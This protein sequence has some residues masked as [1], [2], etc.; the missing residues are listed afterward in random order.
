[1]SPDFRAVR[2]RLAARY[3]RGSGLEIGALHEPL[4]VPAPASVRYVDRLSAE[5]Q[6][7]H[8]PELAGEALVPVDVVDDGE[9]LAT[10]ADASVDFVIANHF[11]EHCEDPIA[12][13]ATFLRVVRSGGIV[14]LAVPDKRFSF[15]AG[16]EIT[17]IGHLLEDHEGGVAA[18]RRGHYLDWAR[19]VLGRNGR[20]AEQEADRLGEARYSI[21]FHVW[22]RRAFLAFLRWCRDDRKMPFRIVRT[23]A[24]R[25]EVIAVLEKTADGEVR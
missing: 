10:I 20:E 16:R 18:S 21:H 1:V 17:T 11:L 6:R 12:A 23:A 8:Y 5:D 2:R 22:T 25:V 9:R 19:H 14:Y 24:N 4:E 7:R 3:L 15:D 13:V